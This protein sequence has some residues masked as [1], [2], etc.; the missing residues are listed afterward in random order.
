[1]AGDYLQAVNDPDGKREDVLDHA[2]RAHHRIP[3]G[4]R[5]AQR[6][7]DLPG[8]GLAYLILI[9]AA[10][11]WPILAFTRR[12]YKYQSD[13]TG[14]ALQL[15][16]ATHATA[17]LFI[18][19]AV[20]WL[21]ILTAVNNDLTALNGGL[22][23]WMRLLQLGLIVAIAGTLAALW[24]AY[25]VGRAPGKHRLA[26]LWAIL[27]ALSAGVPGLAVPRPWALDRVAQLLVSS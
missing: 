6:R 15:R 11:G 27:I 17:W 10:L 16:R 9:I 5:F 3:A 12:R 19:L 13:V 1:M 20:G 18:I 22:D 25:R 23:I 8:A 2:L 7:L 14:R 21:L 24:N 4:A 26:T